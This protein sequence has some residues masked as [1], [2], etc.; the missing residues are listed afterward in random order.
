MLTR[1]LLTLLIAMALPGLPARA[2][3]A[4]AAAAPGHDSA[5]GFWIAT[6]PNGVNVK[7]VI[8]DNGESWGIYEAQGTILGAFHGTIRAARGALYGSG[9]AFDIPSHS[10]GATHYTGSYIPRQTLSLTTAFG[11]TVHSRYVPG[12]DQPAHLTDLQG[13]YRGDG[14]SSRSPV[15]D[16]AMSVAA[17]GAFVMTSTED[18]AASGRATPR[19]GGKAVFDVQLRFAGSACALGDGAS[20]SG[21]AHVSATSGELFV[22][23]MNEARTDGWLFLAQRH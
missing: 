10:V 8:L 20:A 2:A 18:C 22:L 13:R 12:Y 11:A 4:D 7:W 17:D 1:C 14:L 23:A 16:M 5:E 9:L 3:T 6:Q 15:I 21:V 19:P